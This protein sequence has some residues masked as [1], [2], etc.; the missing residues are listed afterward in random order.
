[1]TDGDKRHTIDSEIDTQTA[2][3]QDELLARLLLKSLKELDEDAW[4]LLLSMF[5]QRLG[6]DIQNSLYK[7]GL[8]L[9]QSEDVEQETW[10]IAI[11]QIEQ[12][13][14]H[15]TEQFYHWLRVISHRIILNLQRKV[16][17]NISLDA[18]DDDFI[19]NT[20]TLDLFSYAHG[21]VEES[22]ENHVLLNENL[23]LL[24]KALRDLKP[25]DREIILRR[26]VNGETPAQMAADYGVKPE[27][28]SVILVRA[29][30]AILRYMKNDSPGRDE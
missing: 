19:E 21:F 4:E 25:R 18:L 6:Q 16:K 14:W 12:F 17:D 7:Y 28:V 26:L 23:R 2:K 24:D 10:F 9:E 8:P 27:T 3:S 15:N 1:M 11:R 30:N 22:A 13:V 29:K 5:R 20:L